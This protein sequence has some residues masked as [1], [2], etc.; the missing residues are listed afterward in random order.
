MELVKKVSCGKLPPPPHHS[1]LQTKVVESVMADLMV[2]WPSR[3][4]C[5]RCVCLKSRTDGW[6]A[7]D[8]ISSYEAIKAASLKRI[9]L[10]FIYIF[11]YD[12][13][14]YD[15]PLLIP[16]KAEGCAKPHL[17]N[18]AESVPLFF[19]SRCNL[20]VF[21]I[22]GFKKITICIGSKQRHL[23]VYNSQSKT[24]L[25][26]TFHETGLVFQWHRWKVNNGRTKKQIPVLQSSVDR[27]SMLHKLK[28]GDSFSLIQC[29]S[30]F[31]RLVSGIF[32]PAEQQA[33]HGGGGAG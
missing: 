28:P 12:E 7:D 10:E 16:L 13:T 22:V 21:I 8:K 33:S 25:K 32:P 20:N 31:L 19:F 2:Q 26:C 6:S 5:C 24:A 23:T 17:Q 30:L 29:S 11:L 9:R 14:R 18:N 3:C 15:N 4:S 27:G 1:V